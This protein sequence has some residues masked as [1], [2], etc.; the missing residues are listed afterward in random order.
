MMIMMANEDVRGCRRQCSFV[1]L[2][3]SRSLVSLETQF[4]VDET[5]TD[6]RLVSNSNNNNTRLATCDSQQPPDDR[7][8]NDLSLLLW[9]ARRIL[10]VAKW[11]LQEQLT[12]VWPPQ[13]W[14][15][16]GSRWARL[17][18]LSQPRWFCSSALGNDELKL[19]ARCCSCCRWYAL[20]VAVNQ[21]P[22][23]Q[24]ATCASAILFMSALQER[25][26]ALHPTCS[27]LKRWC[28]IIFT[29]H[30]RAIDFINFSWLWSDSSRA[31]TCCLGW[32]LSAI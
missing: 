13:Y 22:R 15:Q 23:A 25:Q 28:Q 6:T 17:A 24:R 20:L 11:R 18:K 8:A 10:P 12:R 4:K 3:L 32:S 2:S 30:K 9:R 1:A 7:C 5:N 19:S 14:A 27:T 16:I 31:A 26:R 29:L 21:Q